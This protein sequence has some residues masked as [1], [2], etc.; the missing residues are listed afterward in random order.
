M[1]K[2]IENPDTHRTIKSTKQGHVK[3]KKNTYEHYRIDVPS[4]FL[5][6]PTLALVVV[7][8]VLRFALVA[9]M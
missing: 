8:V 9:T 3:K 5:L 4:L 6:S 1:V 7:V 2:T